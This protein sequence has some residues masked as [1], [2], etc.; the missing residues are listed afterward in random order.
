MEPSELVTVGMIVHL[1]NGD[2]KETSKHI[3]AIVVEVVD[4]PSGTA[5][6]REF[7]SLSLVQAAYSPHGEPG[8]WH[9][10]GDEGAL[11]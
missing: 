6:L 9:G 8:S 7:D 3:A 10:V 4:A 11:V 1:V 5:I 2:S